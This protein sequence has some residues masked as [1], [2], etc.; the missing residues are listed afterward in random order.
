[1]L[2]SSKSPDLETR[3]LV[4]FLSTTL[5]KFMCNPR[6]SAARNPHFRKTV[7]AMCIN[8]A[9]LKWNKVISKYLF[10]AFDFWVILKK[11]QSPVGFEK[12]KLREF[13]RELGK[14]LSE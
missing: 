9:I 5:T 7:S 3:H 14:T 10:Y 13:G 1:M 12:K 6:S 11:V 2:E 4:S 8:K